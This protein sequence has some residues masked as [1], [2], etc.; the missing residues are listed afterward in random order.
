MAAEDHPRHRLRRRSSRLDF[1][2]L[3]RRLPGCGAGRRRRDA[4]EEPREREATHALDEQDRHQR[5]D[6]EQR[7]A[8]V[9]PRAAAAQKLCSAG[10]SRRARSWSW[11]GKDAAKLIRG[12]ES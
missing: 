12:K 4:V 2:A 7:P 3:E 8:E 6:Q 11:V 5:D 9:A 1:Q 10:G